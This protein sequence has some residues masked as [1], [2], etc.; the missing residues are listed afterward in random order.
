VVLGCMGSVL[1][2]LIHSVTDFNLQIPANALIF[3][4]VLGV[5]YKATCV[6]PQE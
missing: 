6:E 3:A 2:L 1:A 4:M 5:G